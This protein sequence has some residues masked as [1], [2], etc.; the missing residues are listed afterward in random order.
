MVY[1]V[2]FV[3]TNPKNQHAKEY[4]DHF[5][6]EYLDEFIKVLSNLSELSD[7]WSVKRV[8]TDN[9]L[10]WVTDDYNAYRR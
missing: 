8:W 3:V 7:M 1:H 4:V 5:M 9:K 10:Y 6:T 2:E